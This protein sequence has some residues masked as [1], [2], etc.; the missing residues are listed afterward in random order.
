MQTAQQPL[1]GSFAAAAARAPADCFQGQHVVDRLLGRCARP[2][3]GTSPHQALEGFRF[4][5]K[6]IYR[7]RLH[8]GVD[9]I[10]V[11]SDP[12]LE[13]RLGR[14]GGVIEVCGLNDTVRARDQRFAVAARVEGAGDLRK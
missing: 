2:L 11:R 1:L 9:G 14:I 13:D 5:E 4:G 12:K 8:G 10:V 6:A 3:G 7:A